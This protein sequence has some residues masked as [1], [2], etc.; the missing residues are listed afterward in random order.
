VRERR[1]RD[2]HRMQTRPDK[3]L[4]RLAAAGLCSADSSALLGLGRLG[5]IAN[6]ADGTVLAREGG[7]EPWS[8]FVL[9]GAALLSAHS[10][11]VA[12]A[13]P[14]AW[15]LGHV[16]GGAV[17]DAS[18]SIVAGSDLEV[19]AFRPRDLAAA[20]SLVPELRV[21]AERR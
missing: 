9:D 6:I 11:P 5:D 14:G 7:H 12:V 1:D 20:V 21:A 8:Y 3:K 17:R 16:P 18:V 4:E 2:H 19:L 13:G 15:L 10:T